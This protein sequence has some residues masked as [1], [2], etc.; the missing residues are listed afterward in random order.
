MSHIKDKDEL[1]ALGLLQ[2]IVDRSNQDRDA[3][4]GSMVK[5]VKE[6]RNILKKRQEYKKK[7]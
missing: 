2:R 5:K 7:K 1:W 3:L 6:A 4:P